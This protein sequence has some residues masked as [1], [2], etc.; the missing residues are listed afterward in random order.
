MIEVLWLH[1]EVFLW[2]Q[3][4]T[5]AGTGSILVQLDSIGLLNSPGLNNFYRRIWSGK[6]EW[7]IGYPHIG[8]MG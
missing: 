2:R 7:P 1:D 4:G 3:S 6:K 8:S 5:T